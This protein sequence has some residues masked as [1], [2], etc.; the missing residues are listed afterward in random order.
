M[1]KKDTHTHTRGP[2]GS[3]GRGRCGKKPTKIIYNHD[4]WLGKQKTE[5]D[6]CSCHKYWQSMHVC[7]CVRVCVY[8]AN[9][10]VCLVGPQLRPRCTWRMSNF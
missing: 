8:L 1:S 7:V 10:R 5:P 3:W 6:F 9:V 2:G 4:V